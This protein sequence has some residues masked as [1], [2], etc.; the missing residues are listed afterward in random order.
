LSKTNASLSFGPRGAKFTIGPRGKRA[1][2]GIPG[3]GL[4]YTKK[5]Q[6]KK[7]GNRRSSSKQVSLE[8]KPVAPESTP[9]ASQEN[10]LSMGFFKRLITSDNEV[11]FVD[12]CRELALGDTE[13]AF[14]YLKK[15]AHL[16][17]SAYLAGFFALKQGKNEEAHTLLNSAERNHQSLGQYF[18]KYG[19]SANVTLPITEEVSADIKCNRESVLLGLVE[20]CQRLGRLDEAIQWLEPLRHLHPDDPVIK[21]SLCELLLEQDSSQKNAEGV[22]RIARHVENESAVHAAL[23]LYKAKALRKLGLAEEA[24]ETLTVAMR[25]KKGRSNTLLSA[26]RYERAMAYEDMGQKMQARPDL[27]HIYA[28]DPDYADV[29]K[30]LG[31]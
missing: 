20:A 15:S 12:G 6:D 16:A 30:R 4:F 3:T 26:I 23:L 14:D 8:S 25:R 28:E 19:V 2:V 7:R 27:A 10:Q 29:A 22:V 18:R 17:D 9:V 31:L 24:K 11:A 1:T 13:K 5:L 21:L